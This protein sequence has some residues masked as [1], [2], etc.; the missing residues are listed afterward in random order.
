MLTEREMLVLQAILEDFTKTAQPVA[1][2]T[3]SE[4]EH[5]GY[6]AATIRNIMVELEELGFLEK[7]HTSS[8][9]IPSEKGYRYYVDH[10]VL[11]AKYN[12]VSIL[13]D[14]LQEGI[15][16]FEKVI[17]ISAEVL[18]D[19][20]NCTAI[21]LGPEIFDTKLRQIQI[22]KLS[23]N[24]AIAILITDTGH[25]EH[26]S[27]SIPPGVNM[28]DLE[29]LVNILN[30][31]LVDV[32]I[33][34]IQTKLSDEIS[35]LIKKYI[36]NV[37]EV[38]TLLKS[39]LFDEVPTNIYISGKTNILTQPEFH[40]VNKIHSFYSLIENPETILQLLQHEKKGINVSIGNENEHEMMAD[41]S[42]ITS[43]YKVSQEQFGTIALIGPM[44]MEYKRSIDILH[45]L[46]K[47][48]STTFAQ[49]YKE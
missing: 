17:Q 5:I 16:E 19:L 46:S 39:I 13:N 4:K 25:V 3:I 14:I 37:D 36:H 26:R 43:P 15:V 22:V 41:L 27:F 2:K 6:S 42:V 30:D 20:T 49:I 8:G 18:S 10:V 32:P 47:E 7:T 29:K 28:S 48:I 21:I 38:I 23:P 1:S 45:S 9:R 31:R 35:M 11:P 12:Q 40:D 44:R 33:H 24:T 34:R